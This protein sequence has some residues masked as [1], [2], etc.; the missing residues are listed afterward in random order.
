[1]RQGLMTVLAVVGVGLA[2]PAPAWAVPAKPPNVVII[3]ADDLGFGDV[4]ANGSAT[5]RTPGIDRLAAEGLRFTNVHAAAATC[6]PSR[7]AL[8]TGE[9][10]WRKPGTNVLPGDAAL[11]IDHRR[12]S[13]AAMMR[14]AGYATGLVG[15]WH[16]GL[17]T[18]TID[19]NGDLG[20]GPLDLGFDEAFFIPAT[21]DRVPTVFVED[22]RVVGADPADPIRVSYREPVG[23]EP[24]GKDHPELLKVRPSHGHDQTIV[25]GISR[26][27]YMSGGKAARWVDEDIADTLTRRAVAFLERHAGRPFFLYF[28]THDPHVPRSPHPRFAG[29]SGMGPRGD[30]ILEFDW[31]VSEVVR[32][33]DRLKLS[34][35]TIVIVTSD[36]GPV[37][38]D[39][40]MD[41]AVDLLGQHK[42]SGPYRG[43]KYSAFEAGTRVPFVLRWPAR[44]TRGVSDALVGH[45][46]LFATFAALTGQILPRDA[47]PDS[48]NVL[49]ALLGES[50]RGR[51]W[52]VEQ[53][54]TLSMINGRLKYIEPN[55]GAAVS[56]YTNVEL[57]NA[58]EPQLYDLGADPGERHNLAAGRPDDVAALAQML[59]RVRSGE[60]RPPR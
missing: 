33:L 46:D 21:V 13:L 35:N 15:K 40:Y 1:M 16:L 25:N 5:L 10:A 60:L 22:R 43:G 38:D 27:G 59:A 3:L 50:P 28:S 11:V 42:P 53:A 4:S 56:A 18:G 37:V 54:G 45:I 29:R 57:G 55:K 30:V 48:Q 20:P 6:T 9:Y 26:I 14:S 17:G 39:G 47:A 7:Y 52:L 23:T 2:S 49:P 41:R 24:T 8:L 19:W 32:T 58:P 34:D 12:L 44:V 51:D 36:N 31:C